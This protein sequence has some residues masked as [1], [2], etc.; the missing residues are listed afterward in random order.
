MLT[1]YREDEKLDYVFY[2]PEDVYKV[3]LNAK[4]YYYVSSVGLGVDVLRGLSLSTWF[5]SIRWIYYLILSV[6]ELERK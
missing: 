4:G 3:N 1:L 5:T 2:R 6:G